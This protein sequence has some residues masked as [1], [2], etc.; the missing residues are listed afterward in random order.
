MGQIKKICRWCEELRPLV[1]FGMSVVAVILFAYGV[2]TLRSWWIDRNPVV[3]FFGG[4]ISESVVRPN[5][6]LVIYLNIRKLRD[7]PGVSQRRLT[8]ECGEHILSE[9]ATYLSAGF[10]GRVTLPFQVPSEAIPGQ[11]AFIVH[12]W[13]VCNPFDLIRDRHYVST[14]IPFKILRYNE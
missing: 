9:T 6:L 4:E 1:S 11:C 7:C 10:V 14:P 2:Y 8:G 12:T 3:E 13:Y 5:D